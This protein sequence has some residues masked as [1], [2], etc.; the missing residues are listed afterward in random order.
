MSLNVSLQSELGLRLRSKVLSCYALAE[1]YYLKSFSRPE[2]LINLRG[3]SAGIAELQNNRLRFNAVLLQENEVAFLAEVVPHEIAHLLAWKIYGR[4]IRP[5]GNEWQQIMQQVF[6]L[7]P[8]RTHRF[9]VQRSAKMGYFYGCAC[10][11]KKHALT[12]RRHNR[13]MNGQGYI[14]LLCKSH[15]RFL[16]VDDSLVGR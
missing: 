13:I 12:I 14:C 1:Q 8:S 16:E 4:N 10:V 9:D 15:L 2:L 6:E 11:D 7:S 5:H 3:R